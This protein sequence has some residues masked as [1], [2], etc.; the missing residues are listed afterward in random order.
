MC[1][2]QC[3]ACIHSHT[4]KQASE[5]HTYKDIVKEMTGMHISNGSPVMA[6]KP[7]SAMKVAHVEGAWHSS[8]AAP[9]PAIPTDISIGKDVL[10]KAVARRHLHLLA[11][12][13]K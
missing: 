10:L 6:C 7:P 4:H 9:R 1:E 12:A 13:L 2:R 5:L 11:V 8:S 3:K